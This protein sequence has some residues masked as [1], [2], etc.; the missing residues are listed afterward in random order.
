MELEKARAIQG[1]MNPRELAFLFGI[2]NG[3]PPGGR[4]AE[5]GSWRGRSTVAICEGLQGASMYAVDTFGGD[6]V[7]VERYAEELEEDRV[8][9]EFCDNTAEYA[10]L[11][12]LRMPSAEACT[13]FEDSSLDWVFIDADHSF[14]RVHEDISGWLPKVKPGGLISGHDYPYGPVK[15]AVDMHVRPHVWETIWYAR[16]ARGRPA[17]ASPESEA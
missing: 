13:H 16:L 4:V 7:L 10:F 14:D 5:I 17:G 9:R 2:A 8:Y 1:W 12:V 3:I 6:S 11:E 15:E